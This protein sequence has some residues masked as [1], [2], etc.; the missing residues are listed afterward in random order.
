MD[1]AISAITFMEGKGPCSCL[2][3]QIPSRSVV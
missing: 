1:A 2:F 3:R